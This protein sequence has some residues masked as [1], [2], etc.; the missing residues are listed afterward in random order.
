VKNRDVFVGERYLLHLGC[1]RWHRQHIDPLY[2]AH[3]DQAVDLRTR[4]ASLGERFALE[5]E[6]GWPPPCR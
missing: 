2:Y 4:R 3:A 5:M 1:D 6:T